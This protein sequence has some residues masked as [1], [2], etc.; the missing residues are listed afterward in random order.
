MRKYR[1]L[2]EMF[3]TGDFFY[4]FHRLP[5]GISHSCSVGVESLLGYPQ[6][7]VSATFL[8]DRIHT[9]DQ[10][11]VEEFDKESELFFEKLEKKE[12][13]EYKTRYTFR[14]KNKNGRYKQF[15]FQ[16]IPFRRL[17]NT[18]SELLLIFSDISEL[19]TDTDQH[20]SFIHLS[21]GKSYRRIRSIKQVNAI[22]P[23]SKREREVMRLTAE[24]KDA[25]RIA[26]TLKV[27]PTTVR[28]HLRKMRKKTGTQNTAQL[29]VLNQELNIGHE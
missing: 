21:G 5:D 2:L 24:G 17:D 18:S 6:S 14:L 29:V 12:R 1:V 23:L 20:L 10:P 19:K 25:L 7:D 22:I 3:K 27:S 4:L 13:W 8:F 28:N 9:N 11:A 15:M 26:E 16:S